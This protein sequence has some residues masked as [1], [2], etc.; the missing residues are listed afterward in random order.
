MEYNTHKI[1]NVEKNMCSVEQK[2]AYN[3][4]FSWYRKN[5]DIELYNY[6]VS[7]VSSDIDRHEKMKKYD[8]KAIMQAFKNGFLNYCNNFFIAFDYEKI[9]SCF[10]L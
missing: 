2:I 5:I 1:Q 3:Y 10:Y 9:G 8:K 4:A 6:I 7:C